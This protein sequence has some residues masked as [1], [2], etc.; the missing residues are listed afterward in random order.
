MSRLD[1]DERSRS[2]VRMIIALGKRLGISVVAEGVE[3]EQQANWLRDNGC[4][5]GQ[6]W[7]FGRPMPLEDLIQWLHKRQQ[8]ER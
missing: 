7:L 5:V 3:T 8:G 6:G 2:L 4:N 1:K